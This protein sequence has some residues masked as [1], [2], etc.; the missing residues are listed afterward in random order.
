MTF[1]E[2][3]IH[4]D[5]SWSEERKALLNVAISCLAKERLS[6]CAREICREV[7]IGLA[8]RSTSLLRIVG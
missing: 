6:V 5:A 2:Q 8:E 4:L 3:N 7:K 1:F